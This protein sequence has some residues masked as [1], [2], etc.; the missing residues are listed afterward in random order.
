MTVI[1]SA[2][3]PQALTM[4]FVAEFAAPPARVWQVWEDPGSW[5]AGG[6]RRP[7]RPPS[8]AMSSPRAGS[9]AIT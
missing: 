1:S 2:A 7:G 4:T 3:D 5:N 6:V 8:P 9:R